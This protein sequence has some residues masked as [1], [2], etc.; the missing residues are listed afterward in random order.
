[1][2]ALS[3]TFN[4]KPNIAVNC[5]WGQWSAWDTCSVTC[6]GGTQ[7]RQRSITQEALYGGNECIGENQETQSCNS[8]GCPGTNFSVICLQY[9]LSNSNQKIPNFQ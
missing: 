5:T 8:N 7:D 3:S 2:M 9:V 4:Q 1:M 6:G